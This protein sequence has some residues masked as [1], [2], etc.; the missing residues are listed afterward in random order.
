MTPITEL[1]ITTKLTFS[2]AGVTFI[3]K[4]NSAKTGSGSKTANF[5]VSAVNAVSLEALKLNE[6]TSPQLV[7]W[8]KG[9]SRWLTRANVIADYNDD[10]IL[11][12]VKEGITIAETLTGIQAACDMISQRFD[13]YESSILA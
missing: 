3:L 5:T 7:D 1:D 9:Y 2:S 10:G 6:D 13:H 4:C 12:T 8:A 11:G